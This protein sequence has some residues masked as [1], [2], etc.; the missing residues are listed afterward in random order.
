[1]NTEIPESTGSERL[2]RIRKAVTERGWCV[3]S[4]C[5]I[6]D[7]VSRTVK[8]VPAS[9]CHDSY[10]VAKAFVV[11][12]VGILEDRGLLS[13]EEKVYPIFREKFREGFDQKWQDVTIDHVLR[14]MTGFECGFLDIDWEDVRAYPTDDYLDM[15]LNHPLKYEPGTTYV[16]S[17]AAYY[18]LSRIITAKC[19]E[20]LDDFLC[21]E[22]FSPM[23]FAEFA[24]SK[25]PCGYPMGATGLYISTED[26]AKLGQLYLQNGVWEG[27]QILS[28][29]FV[30]KALGRY[31]FRS[32]YGGY[33][34]GGMYGQN[35]YL[36]P[37]RHLVIAFHGF[38]ISI[39]EM[40]ALANPD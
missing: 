8:I 18:L 12:A 14:H 19:G 24:F 39:E 38:K 1:M 15:V 40:M 25:C 32:A 33:A 37:V 7:G 2:D 5:E 10:S 35:L 28:E 3:Y 27:R 17:D 11:T 23:H 20:R 22:L 31:E 30:K 9:N 29:Q 21:R 4:V 34:K 6:K 13:T 26:M 36:D 16:Y